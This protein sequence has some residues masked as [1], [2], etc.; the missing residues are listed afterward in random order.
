[1]LDETCV[2]DDSEALELGRMLLAVS[3]IRLSSSSVIVR[4]RVVLKT[5]V[6]GE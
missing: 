5:T 3:K 4:V 2:K 1:M 6:A